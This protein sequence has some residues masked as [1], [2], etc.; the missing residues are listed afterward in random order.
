MC[1]V[2]VDVKKESKLAMD[3]TVCDKEYKLPT[4]E[5]ILIGRERFAAAEILFD[6][7]IIDVE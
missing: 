5:T 2:S 7:L 6:P 1:Y 3:T 4:G